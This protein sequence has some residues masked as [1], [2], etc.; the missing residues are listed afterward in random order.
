MQI[1][2][3]ASDTIRKNGKGDIRTILT[4][5]ASSFVYIATICMYFFIWNGIDEAKP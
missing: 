1:K 4:F 3:S 2:S 5:V